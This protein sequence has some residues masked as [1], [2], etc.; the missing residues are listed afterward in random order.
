MLLE[1]IFITVF[2]NE[3]PVK[4]ALYYLMCWRILCASVC[5]G[6][7][8]LCSATEEHHLSCYIVYFRIAS[9]LPSDVNY[10]I[11]AFNADVHPAFTL[12]FCVYVCVCVCLCLCDTW[13]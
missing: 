4:L 5:V 9:H 8:L 11:L 2:K 3:N 1:S 13:V 12:Y 10:V 6:C 7:S